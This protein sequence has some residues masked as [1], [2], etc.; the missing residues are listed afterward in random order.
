[1]LYL[2]FGE[3]RIVPSSVVVLRLSTL[4]EALGL[5]SLPIEAM[6]SKLLIT[7]TNHAHNLAGDLAASFDLGR[8]RDSS[9]RKTCASTCCWKS[10]AVW[11]GEPVMVD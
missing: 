8:A 5:L 4:L 1:M 10:Q 7:F 11:R 6:D 3:G 2:T 9:F